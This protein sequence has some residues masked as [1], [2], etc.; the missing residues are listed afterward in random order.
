L[1]G[2]DLTT[3]GARRSALELRESISDPDA[4]VASE[5]WSIAATTST[6]RAVR[7]VRLNEDTFSFQI[8]EA[9]G[10]L[11]SLPKRDL[12]DV[13]LNRRSPMP[14]FKGTLSEAQIDDVIAWLVS[15]GRNR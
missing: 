11:M 13:E 8:R 9:N 7:G 2:P 3:A 15:L 12:K 4:Q 1:T 14:S 6:G 10:H 5:Y